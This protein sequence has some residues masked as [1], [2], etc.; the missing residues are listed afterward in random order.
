MQIEQVI[1]KFKEE[2]FQV[3]YFETKEEA[4]KYLCEENTGKTIGFGGSM[5][6]EEMGLFE[7]LEKENTVIWHWKQPAQEAKDKAATAQVYLSSA[8]GISQTGEIVNIDGNGNRVASITYGHDKVYIVVGINKIEDTLERAMWRA[9]NI[10]APLNTRRMNCKTPCAMGEEVKC[11]DCKSPERIC[12]SFSII[13]RKV[14]G[15]G[16]MELILI[17]EALGY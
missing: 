2:G 7:A 9:R 14:L 15:V 12:R 1:T 8:N 16:E 5:T 4:T 10:A 6:L 3:S 11:F 13:N 17:N